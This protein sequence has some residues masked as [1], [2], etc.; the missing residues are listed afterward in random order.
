MRTLVLAVMLISLAAVD[1]ARPQESPA[2]PMPISAIELEGTGG[3]PGQFWRI[4]FNSDYTS[5]WFHQ[6]EPREGNYVG[7]LSAQQWE[8][9]VATMDRLGASQLAKSYAQHV[10]DDQC[11]TLKVTRGAVTQTVQSSDDAGPTE[12]WAIH[13]VMRGMAERMTWKRVYKGKD[14]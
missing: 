8:R 7:K 5:G 13:M 14:K 10:E 2:A 11:L 12:L 9:L 3:W 6:T 4:S 1:P